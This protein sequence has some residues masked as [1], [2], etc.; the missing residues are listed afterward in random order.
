MDLKKRIAK[1]KTQIKEHQNEILTAGFMLTTAAAT[2]GWKLTLDKLEK[3]YAGNREL[4]DN[5]AKGET[6]GP[7]AVY[8]DEKTTDELLAGSK[9]VWFDVRGKRCDLTLHPED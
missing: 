8:L 3:A 7:E 5:M 9:D 4:L 1:I 2:I 6:F